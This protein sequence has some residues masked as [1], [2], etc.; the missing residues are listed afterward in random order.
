MDFDGRKT[1][2]TIILFGLMIV[3]FGF[4]AHFNEKYS[5]NVI[6]PYEMGQLKE[7][8]GLNN[9]LSYKLPA[10]FNVQEKN[11]NSREIIYHSDFAT[12]DF[13]IRGIVEV[14][15]FDKELKRFLSLSKNFSQVQ[16]IITGY[17]IQDII[18]GGRPGYFVTY[19]MQNQSNQRYKAMEYF[20]KYNGG[21]LRMSFYIKLNAYNEEMKPYLENILRT[22]KFNE[23]TIS[24]RVLS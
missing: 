24:E 8:N 9:K 21:F 14:W 18:V 13:N 7:H 1:G 15:N 23:T 11:L 16:N 17:D 2:I 6:F 12:E 5:F 22:L 19:T 4:T 3:L 20:I 10:T